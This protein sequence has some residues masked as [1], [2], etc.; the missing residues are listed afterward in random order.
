MWR[1]HLS[2][3]VLHEMGKTDPVEIDQFFTAFD[4]QKSG[5]VDFREVVCGM[6]VVQTGSIDDRLMMAFKA[7]ALCSFSVAEG[8]CHSVFLSLCLSVFFSVSLSPC[9]SV[10]LPFSTSLSLCIDMIGILSDPSFISHPITSPFIVTDALYVFA[11]PSIQ[12][13]TIPTHTF[14]QTHTQ[15]NSYD[16]DGS[17][18]IDRQELFNIMS[19]SLRMKG[20]LLAD[21]AVWAMVEQCFAV[22]DADGNGALDFEEFKMAIMQQKVM[23]QSFW[24]V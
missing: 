18:G 17:G 5:H 7:Y 10:S 12:P 15:T 19:S 23:L 3:Q 2:P 20:T 14:S 11:H 9:L 6:S 8:V 24:Q 4:T 13:N 16:L 22:A 21:E 1:A